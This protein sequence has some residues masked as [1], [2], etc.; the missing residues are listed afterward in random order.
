MLHF[1]LW[2]T[3]MHLQ[4]RGFFSLYLVILVLAAVS[5]CKNPSSGNIQHSADDIL[6]IPDTK[7]KNYLVGNTDINTNQ[8][9]EIQYSEAWD[10][11]G[12]IYVPRKDICNFT[13]IEAFTALTQLNNG[14]NNLENLDLS[15]NIKLA[16][17][18]CSANVNLGSLNL[19]TNTEL[20]D[21]Y[22]NGNNLNSLNLHTN[23]KLQDLECCGNNLK[24]LDLSA[25][26]A[27]QELE[28]CRNNLKSLDLSANTALEDLDCRYNDLVTLDLSANT[29]L[30]D[31]D[32]RYNN[33]VTLDVSTIENLTDLDC[34][35]NASL[36]TIYVRA[37]QI[38]PHPPAHWKKP[39]S[40]E[41]Q[42][43]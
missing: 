9:D 10:F 20:R 35:N 11:T 17:L 18:G 40:A 4:K 6:Y 37:E 25:N 34:R 29:A 3:N 43:R 36:T 22:C 31:L 14:S 41:Y 7:F 19:S 8:D 26:T 30:E 24:S 39:A 21:L 2:R 33:L 16:R 42:V 32:C 28:C 38:T 1:F 13:G 12:I 27:L 5:G 15:A 23:T